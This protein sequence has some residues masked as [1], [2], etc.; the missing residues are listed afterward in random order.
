MRSSERRPTWQHDVR[1]LTA[2]LLVCVVLVGAAIS[3][4]ARLTAPGTVEPV[5][6]ALLGL[7]V[8]PSDDAVRVAPSSPVYQLG[9]PLP[10]LPGVPVTADATEIPTFEPDAAIGRVAGVL[11]QRLVDTGA[12]ATWASVDDA[13]WRQVLERAE[14]GLIR[15]LVRA[16]LRSPLF[17]VGIGDGTRAANWPQQAQQ[18]P[19]AEVQPLVGVFVTAPPLALQGRS[20]REVGEL[21]VGELARLVVDQGAP[22]ARELITNAEVGAA[23]DA[24]VAGPVRAAVHEAVAAVTASRTDEI[25]QRL[26][27]ARAVL[28][29][30]TPERDPW[31]GLVDSGD[32]GRLGDVERRDRVL[33]ELAQRASVGGSD[34]VLAALPA[35]G[36]RERVERASELLDV[37]GRDAH[38]R[39]TTWAWILGAVALLL[40]L[41]VALTA[42]GFGRVFAPG[43]AVLVGAAPGLAVSLWL[44][45]LEPVAVWPAGPALEGAVASL[46]D[47][48]RLALAQLAPATAETLVWAHLVPAG[49]G[50]AFVLI[51]VSGALAAQL[52]PSR[53]GRF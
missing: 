7:V 28:A 34:A 8:G 20:P 43:L 4:L 25:A 32:L 50:A 40:S 15:P 38:R 36:V 11:A 26:G 3:S 37:V 12:S 41:I 21:V 48:V 18:N 46:V 44:R 33:D 45:T 2:L 14:E 5:A 6:R 27:E 49:I 47:T 10:L 42:E 51:G 39:A 29:G 30:S 24:A 52:R 19:G 13:D 23:F 9:T 35:S 1:W 16:A 53:R 22:A 17:D 31:A